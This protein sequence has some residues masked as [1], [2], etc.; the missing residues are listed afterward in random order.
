ML[1]FITAC[2]EQNTKQ[3]VLK[4]GISADYPPF[5]FLKDGDLQGLEVDLAM[6]I[7]EELGAKVQ[8]V[9]MDFNSIFAAFSANKIDLGISAI[10]IT[11]ER[12][13]NINFSDIYFTNT[14]D[15]ITFKNREDLI[16]NFTD[17]KIGVQLGSTMESFA[18]S[19]PGVNVISLGLNTMLIQELK[20]GRLDAII[21]EHVQAVEFCK[22]HPELSAQTM[23]TNG[24]G[25]AVALPKR[26]NLTEKVS[27]II[28]KFKQ[29]GKLKNIQDKW[30]NYDNI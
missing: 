25:Y 12:A 29:S 15:L 6:A 10:T 1:V 28:A 8:F 13:K 27:L 30:V 5:A 23:G 2:Q 9:N 4:V 20:L 18:K 21:C 22:Q 19:I 16:N 14:F 17:K 24:D 3:E 7:G 26:S 11:P